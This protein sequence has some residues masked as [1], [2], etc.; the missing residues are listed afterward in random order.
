MRPAPLDA[1]RHVADAVLY[2]GY[3]LFPYRASAPKNRYRWQW[4]VVVPAAQVERGWS[5]PA[6]IR[7]EVPVRGGG[8]E[9]TAS[10]RFLHLRHRQVETP[11]GDPV[12]RLEVDDDLLVT[13]DEGLEQE[14]ATPTLAL[15]AL[16]GAPHR[17]PFHLDG[18][19]EVEIR[20]GARIVRTVEPVDGVIE[21][22]AHAVSGDVAR[23][24]V[25]VANRTDWSAPRPP[26]DDV[27]RRSLVGAHVMLA[28]DGGSFGSVIDPPDWAR[29]AAADCRSRTV[30][31]VLV[32]DDDADDVVLAAPIILEDHPQVAPESPGPSFDGLEIDELLA[33]CVRGL[34]DDEKREA[35]ATDPR[36]AALIDRSDTLPPAVLERLHGTIREFGPSVGLLP[37]PGAGVDAETADFF[38]VGEEPLERAEIDGTAVSVGDTVRLAPR[39]RADAH[40]LFAVGRDAV[41]ERIVRTV[42]GDTLLA[43][44]LVDDPA[45]ELHRWYGRF[46]YFH[47]DEVEAPTLEEAES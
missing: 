23:L 5:E 35:R 1:A 32:G 47:L 29:A 45:A 7:C 10:I 3:V 28:V 16:L 9:I 8:A 13:W 15:G 43:V 46:Q 31:P 21:I 17:Q 25:T 27:L 18:G 42:D 34:T 40:D 36:A 44:T 24:T 39:R 37:D 11:D 38:G 22:G 33:L 19:R 26:R 2:E 14:V 12:D 20:G 30:F 41:V 4:G 6:Q